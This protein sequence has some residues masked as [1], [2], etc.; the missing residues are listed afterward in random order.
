ML[1]S[2]GGVHNRTLLDRLAARAPGTTMHRS[3]EL[4]LPADAKEAVLFALVGWL[5][6]HGLPGAVPAA[7]GANGPRVAGSITPGAEPLRLP[8]PLPAIPHKLEMD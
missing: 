3:E 2:G 1:L 7:T 5:T 6:W 4:G 8:P